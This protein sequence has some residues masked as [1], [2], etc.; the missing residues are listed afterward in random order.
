MSNWLESVVLRAV[1]IADLAI[2]TNWI[3]QYVRQRPW[4]SRQ[5]WPVGRHL[6]SFAV[7]VTALL[8]VSLS[9]N[10][11]GPAPIWMW[12]A[13]FAALGAV[14]VHRTLLLLRLRRQSDDESDGST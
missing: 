2:F 4:R 13:G 5:T 3:L 9:Q 14:G 10:L 1:L 12:L 7:V 8:A 11:F 6:I